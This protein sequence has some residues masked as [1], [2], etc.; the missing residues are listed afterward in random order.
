MLVIVL[1]VVCSVTSMAQLT[2]GFRGKVV[3]TDGKPLAGATVVFTNLDD[4]SQT[5]EVKTD[6]HGYYTQAGL[7]FADKGYDIRVKT[8]NMQS[9]PKNEKAELM[10]LHVV[11][12]D[13]REDLAEQKQQVQDRPAS[14]ARNLFKMGDYEGAITKANEAVAKD[15]NVKVALFIKGACY[16]KL[17][18]VDGA[19][20]AF[21]S[22]SKKFPDA[23]NS[24]DVLGY[25]GKLYE[26]KGDKKKSEFY[27]KAFAAKGG[28]ILNQ[29]FNDGVAAY[30]SGDFAKAVELF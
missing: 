17:G 13:L 20:E 7:P 22:Y 27:K 3:G 30:N 15:D 10:T 6:E 1:A 14:E 4:V 21:E 16:E 12:F 23:D 2:K 9:N 8:D 18:N 5:W 19:I 11:N 25:L 24:T 26:E 28:K 29:T